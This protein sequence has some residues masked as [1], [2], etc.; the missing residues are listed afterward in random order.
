MV[1]IQEATYE[2]QYR[3]RLKFSTG[4]EGVVDL[5]DIIGRYPAARPLREVEAF[6]QFYLDEWPTL[7]WP[8]GFDLAPEWLYE[9]ATGRSPS[10][11]RPTDQNDVDGS[12]KVSA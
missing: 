7:A 9:L 8:C 12:A 1:T 6:S 10:W 2:G 3:I 11:L 4:E 5:S